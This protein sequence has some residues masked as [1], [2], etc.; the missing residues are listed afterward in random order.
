MFYSQPLI[1][2]LR[3]E[4]H[5]PKIVFI[6]GIHNTLQINLT[7]WV[8]DHPSVNRTAKSYFTTKVNRSQRQSETK[9]DGSLKCNAAN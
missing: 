8:Y 1:E 5:G 9:L 3:L 6:K 7:A 4:E 2:R